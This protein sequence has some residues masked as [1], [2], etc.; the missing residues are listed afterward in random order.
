[1]KQINRKSL[2]FR[3]MAILLAALLGMSAP[4]LAAAQ[5]IS[6]DDERYDYE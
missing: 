3:S 5:L 2:W 1:M 4:V 6:Y